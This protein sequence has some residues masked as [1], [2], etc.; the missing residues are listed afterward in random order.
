[1]IKD[2][3]YR[4]IDNFLAPRP[5]ALHFIK[6][7]LASFRYFEKNLSVRSKGRRIFARRRDFPG[8]GMAVKSHKPQLSCFSKA[9][10]RQHSFASIPRYVEAP[11]EKLR[12]QYIGL[13][14]HQIGDA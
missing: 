3:T 13:T 4:L 14:G 6:V 2:R 7:V 5:I 10:G 1:M 8:R 11:N 12:H 9:A